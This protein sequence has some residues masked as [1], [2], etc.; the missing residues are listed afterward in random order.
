MAERKRAQGKNMNETLALF[1]K[2]KHLLNYEDYELNAT[3]ES[4]FLCNLR[5]R[6]NDMTTMETWYL[7]LLDIYVIDI[8]ENTDL[9]H[10][11]EYFLQVMISISHTI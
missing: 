3:C 11:T 4:R 2:T 7:V 5:Y 1:N 10:P 8:I 6:H 9:K